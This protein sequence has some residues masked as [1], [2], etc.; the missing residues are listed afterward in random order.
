MKNE[1]QNL[2]EFKHKTFETIA[3]I[4]IDQLFIQMSYATK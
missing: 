3:K 2:W 1:R 4:G